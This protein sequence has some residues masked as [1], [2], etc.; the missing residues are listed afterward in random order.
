MKS[1]I[2]VFLTVFCLLFCGCHPAKTASP[3]AAKN[4][5]PARS[6]LV[7]P[8]DTA[9]AQ[10]FLLVRLSDGGNVSI[11]TYPRETVFSE[12][13]DDSTLYTLFA[14]GNAGGCS[15]VLTAFEQAGVPVDRI[16]SVCVDD[17]DRGLYPLLSSLGNNLLFTNPPAFVYTK[18]NE[19]PA[20]AAAWSASALRQA[21]ALPRISDSDIVPYA[22][23]RA[24]VAAAVTRGLSDE[25]GDEP[26]TVF[27]LLCAAGHSSLSPADRAAFTALFSTSP[28]VRLCPVYG[29][30]A[31]TGNRVRFYPRAP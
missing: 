16:L 22:T 29:D 10:A 2:L 13:A 12:T 7:V 15:R 5:P 28:R 8:F 31:G 4:F 3:A 14:D 19:S 27:S 17:A 11:S 23:F 18:P 20:T 21:L 1:R 9:G 6:L 25:F 26:D 30:T 24:Q